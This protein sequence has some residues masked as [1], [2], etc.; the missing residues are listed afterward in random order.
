MADPT[1]APEAGAVQ[2]VEV[3]PQ[4][5]PTEL[6][7]SPPMPEVARAAVR[8]AFA[9]EAPEPATV[10]LTPRGPG[11]PPGSISKA[12]GKRTRRDLLRE[13]R[14]LS[15]RLK[16]AGGSRPAAEPKAA[17]P[18]AGEPR[19]TAEPSP[20]PEVHF[21]ATPSPTVDFDAARTFTWAFLSFCFRAVAFERGEHWNLR[22]EED[23]LWTNSLGDG[24]APF[25][26]SL[27]AMLPWLLGGM[28]L[29]SAIQKRAG[30]DK[31]KKGEG[32]HGRHAPTP[33]P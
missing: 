17:E 20:A 19:A 7:A 12:K 18:P 1:G 30:E 21:I 13:N 14:E 16:A 23:R 32:P 26:P 4:A 8:E 28:G 27:G 33:T 24:I 11:R 25:L 3:S 2:T 15:E 10:P 6:S 9:T 29:V 22:E 5:E 31:V